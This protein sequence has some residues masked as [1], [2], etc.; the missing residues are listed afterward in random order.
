MTK[1]MTPYEVRSL[2][3]EAEEKINDILSP[4]NN[5]EPEDHR[6]MAEWLDDVRNIFSSLED[7]ASWVTQGKPMISNTLSR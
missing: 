3:G 1:T 2:L 5:L 4:G 7:E 6:Q